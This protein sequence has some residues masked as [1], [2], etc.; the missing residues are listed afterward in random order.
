MRTIAVNARRGASDEAEVILMRILTIF[1]A[2]IF[3]VAGV[4]KGSDPADFEAA[5]IRLGLFPDGMISL[6]AVGIPLLEFVLGL[7]CLIASTAQRAIQG[8]VALTAL[9][10]LLLS[11]EWLR[12]I[13]VGCGCF[14]GQS[15]HWP[16]W[17][18]LLRNLGLLLL[19][20]YLL[21]QQMLTKYH[22]VGYDSR[23]AE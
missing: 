1:L 5:L 6:V 11:Y 14:G 7:M 22:S 23:I 19:E 9:Y 2:S 15:G 17:A 20:V 10:T 12:G 18:L 13:E 16:H 4:E 3:V 21:R 8:L